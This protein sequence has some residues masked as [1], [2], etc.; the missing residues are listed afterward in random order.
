MKSAK[1]VFQQQIEAILDKIDVTVTDLSTLI[2]AP[3]DA[4]RCNQITQLVRFAR[5]ALKDGN[6]GGAMGVAQNAELEANRLYE[7]VMASHG[8]TE[9]AEPEGSQT[10][11]PSR[12]ST[13]FEAP[14]QDVEEVDPEPSLQQA[15]KEAL[16]E[17]MVERGLVGEQV[18]NAAL[19]CTIETVITE[20]RS[21]LVQLAEASDSDRHYESCMQIKS[22]IQK[23]E[24]ALLNGDASMADPLSREAHE[25]AQKTRDLLLNRGNHAGRRDSLQEALAEINA[26]ISKLSSK[27]ILLKEELRTIRDTAKSRLKDDQLEETELLLNKMR[28]ILHKVEAP[29]PSTIQHNP[30]AARRLKLK[31]IR[32]EWAIDLSDEVLGFLAQETIQEDDNGL[33]ELLQRLVSRSLLTGEKITRD[34]ARETLAKME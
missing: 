11:T 12:T 26:S 31:K 7:D 25:L 32:S 8:K 34:M 33:A 29:S 14:S 13:R 5:Q 17:T 30:E 22:L 9:S 16:E 15:A 27:D 24:H 2:D 20:T 6:V 3:Q 21:I 23:A 19:F 10:V 1:F 4:E 28:L 18:Q